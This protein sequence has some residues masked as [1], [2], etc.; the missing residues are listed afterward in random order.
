MKI[1]INYKHYEP[2]LVRD[3]FDFETNSTDPIVIMNEILN[4]FNTLVLNEEYEDAYIENVRVIETDKIDPYLA[5]ALDECDTIIPEL[6]GFD[7]SKRLYKEDDEFRKAVGE[8]YSYYWFNYLADCGDARF[9]CVV[10]ALSFV[11]KK[12]KEEGEIK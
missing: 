11:Y 7:N 10:D 8:K 1:R 6:E 12:W 2:D 4:T 9:D 3:S 5:D